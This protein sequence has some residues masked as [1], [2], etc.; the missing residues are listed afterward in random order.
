MAAERRQRLEAAE[1]RLEAAM[2]QMGEAWAQKPVIRHYMIMGHDRPLHLA[3][4]SDTRKPALRGDTRREDLFGA[5]LEVKPAEWTVNYERDI[6]VFMNFKPSHPGNL[7]LLVRRP[8]DYVLGWNIQLCSWA[9]EIR[10]LAL[11]VGEHESP[12]S[13]LHQYDLRI[14]SQLQGLRKIYVIPDKFASYFSK[15]K[16]PHSPLDGDGYADL[17]LCLEWLEEH[18][19]SVVDPQ[20]WQ[21]M[22]DQTEYG[23]AICSLLEQ[24]LNGHVSIQLMV[25]VLRS[26]NCGIAIEDDPS[27]TDTLPRWLLDKKYE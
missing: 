8:F 11:Y 14:I 12:Q 5:P 19:H 9:N 3:Y 6:F 1:Q 4:D 25:D 20:G 24:T 15:I 7:R 16:A 10:Y 23:R 13:E 26:D 18:G 27:L 17:E 21:I 2:Q 22:K